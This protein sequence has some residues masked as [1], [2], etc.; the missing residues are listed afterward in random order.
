MPT[1]LLFAYAIV[2]LLVFAGAAFAWWTAYNSRDRRDARAR[3][4]LAERYRVRDEAAGRAAT[5]N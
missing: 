1:R 3:A 2:A 4:R 5:D